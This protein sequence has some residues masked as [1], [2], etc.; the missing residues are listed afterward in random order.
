MPVPIS[1]RKKIKMSENKEDFGVS[2]LKSCAKGVIGFAG[3]VFSGWAL[4]LTWTWI[5]VTFLHAPP[6]GVLACIALFLIRSMIFTDLSI[7][8]VMVV[9]AKQM[10]LDEPMLHDVYDW[11]GTWCVGVAILWVGAT[12]HY[13]LFP[14]LIALGLS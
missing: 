2:L 4:S 10:K 14:L 9:G 1:Y 12:W 7:S 8:R 3:T 11:V 5:A 13:A 6:L